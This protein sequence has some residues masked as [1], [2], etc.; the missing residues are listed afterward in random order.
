M[1]QMYVFSRFFLILRSMLFEIKIIVFL[2][3]V[4]LPWHIL[5]IIHFLHLLSEHIM[6]PKYMKSS[7]CSI[8]SPSFN[9]I[10]VLMLSYLIH[11][12]IFVFFVFIFYVNLFPSPVP[13]FLK[14][15]LDLFNSP[16]LL[17]YHLLILAC[18]SVTI[19]RGVYRGGIPIKLQPPPPKCFKNLK[20][21]LNVC[22]ILMVLYAYLEFAS[23]VKSFWD[24]L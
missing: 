4:T 21:I 6:L 22:Y 23:N 3:N 12:S 20:I 7:T 5:F 9:F 2:L 18:Y 17:Q 8:V 11:S 16:L 14:F 24:I 10:L 19:Y 1:L 15:F 13:I